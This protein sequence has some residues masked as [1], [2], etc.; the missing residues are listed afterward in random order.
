MISYKQFIKLFRR[1]IFWV[2]RTY[3]STCTKTNLYKEVFTLKI[4][5][6]LITFS[7]PG[8]RYMT[9]F[10]LCRGYLKILSSF[11]RVETQNWMKDHLN[12]LIWEIS[13]SIN[14]YRIEVL[15]HDA[16]QHSLRVLHD[17]I[18]LMF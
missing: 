4:L 7:K 2:W 15:M 3:A 9:S 13:F 12:E 5:I 18:L 11:Y 10:M 17:K 1:I 8:N 16:T 6:L 14:K